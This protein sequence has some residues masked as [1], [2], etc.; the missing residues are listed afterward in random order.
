ML[1]GIV[2]LA[3]ESADAATNR[4]RREPVRPAEASIAPLPKGPLFAVVALAEQRITVYSG[5]TAVATSRISSG[6]RG[7]ATPTGVF[8]TLQKNRFHRSNIYSG[9]P[10]PFM[11]RLT[12]S[13]I[14]LHAGVLP[15][16]PAS[17][18]CVRLPP[19]FAQQLFASLRLG[20]RVI[21]APSDVTPQLFSNQ[22]LPLPTLTPVSDAV[23]PTGPTAALLPGNAVASDTAPRLIDPMQLGEIEKRRIAAAAVQARSDAQAAFAGAEVA[24]REHA[25]ALAAMRESV[26]AVEVLRSQ[27]AAAGV[28]R[29]GPR[30][31]A[32]AAKA[33]EIAATATAALPAAEQASQAARQI[34]A[35]TSQRALDLAIAARTADDAADAA[36]EAA[37]VARS[38]A[39]PITILV[40]RKDSKVFVRQ[41]WDTV[42]EA[43]A[44][45][46][47]PSQA[48]GTHVFKLTAAGIGDDG[49]PTT[50]WAAVRVPDA[51]HGADSHHR[52]LE[53]ITLPEAARAEISRRLWTGATF[54][55]SDNGPGNETGRYTDLIVQTR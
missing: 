34:E 33:A 47:D 21:V 12:W 45:I 3:P 20:S 50:T 38:R 6:K 37:R 49:R 48:I 43:E 16:Y 5:T 27:I 36:A 55:I 54:M 32:D 35:E 39:E 10:M 25:A 2:L 11:Q 17:H 40:S 22:A 1:T 8:S 46:E 52:A 7:H 9:A 41:G 24:A 19:A 44:R 51:A 53:R 31:A 42:L 14:A 26:R 23:A 28:P 13:G 18:G 15:G 4:T 30:A 29:A